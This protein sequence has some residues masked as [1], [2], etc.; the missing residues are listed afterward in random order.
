MGVGSPAVPTLG[1]LCLSEAAWTRVS[2]AQGLQGWLGIVREMES[3]G[4]T[5][6]T[7]P[8]CAVTVWGCIAKVLSEVSLHLWEQQGEGGTLPAQC[9][10]RHLCGWLS[11]QRLIPMAAGVKEPCIS[12]PDSL[13]CFTSEMVTAG[14][15]SELGGGVCVRRGS[16][17]RS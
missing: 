3:S 15:G 16:S 8:C 10:N 5:L 12:G 9:L 2:C 14:E 13:G 11:M 4:P 6:P 1:Q 7:H 17:P